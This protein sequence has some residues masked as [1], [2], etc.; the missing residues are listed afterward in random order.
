M[1]NQSE[2]ATL[3]AIQERMQWYVDQNRIPCCRYILAKSG[4]LLDSQCI[5]YIDEARQ[6][7]LTNEA[8]FRIYSNTKLIT[9]VAVML[10]VERGLIQLDAPIADLCSKFSSLRV[11]KPNATSVEQTEALKVPLTLRHLLSHTAGFSYGFVDPDTL[12][13]REYLNRGFN[14]LQPYA[15][16]L[17]HFVEGILE[18]PLAFQP[19]TGWR[20]SVATDIVGYIIELVTGQSLDR[21]LR[22]QLF[23]PLAMSDTGFCVPHEKRHHIVELLQAADMYRP[24]ET[25]YLSQPFATFL[26]ITSPPNFLSG[27]GGLFSTAEDYLTFLQ[28]LQAQ[29]QWLGEQIIQPQTLQLMRQDQL[30]SGVRMTF[31]MWSLPDVG[32]GLGLALK[33][34]LIDSAGQSP[35]FFWG[36]MA[37]THCWVFDNGIVG[38]CM[39]QMMPS[40]LHP[41]SSDF[42]RLA[43]QLHD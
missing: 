1:S 3:Q 8:I 26:P 10:L 7:P 42:H 33:P 40:F 28:M 6:L 30:P 27:G 15:G 9:S 25:G 18:M 38:L 32:F 19:G 2:A 37:G 22:E 39:T 43:S 16:N 4:R 34:A 21:F 41:F 35:C 29:G 20:Y 11:L 12:I 5:G 24:K 14:L 31:P 17:S 36:G 13:D 23:E